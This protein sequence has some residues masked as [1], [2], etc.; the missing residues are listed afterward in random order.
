MGLTQ[1]TLRE[2]RSE[3]AN[4]QRQKS[5]VDA[6]IQGIKVILSSR[7]GVAAEA[8]DP[9]RD[10]F[11]RAPAVAAQRRRGAKGSLR[12]KLTEMLQGTPGLR[13][14][15]IADRLHRED[16]QIGGTTDLRVRVSHELSRLRRLKV[17][18]RGRGGRYTLTNA[19]ARDD[20]A[21][22]PKPSPTTM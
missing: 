6:R 10:R 5:E 2:L 7:S 11:A 3:L 4:L 21:T 17:V 15:E 8:K 20:A 1:G 19:N 12:K 14:E 18:R 22:S 9:G 16:F 13:T